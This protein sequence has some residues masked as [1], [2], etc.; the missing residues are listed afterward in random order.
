M[1]DQCIVEIR[2]SADR[3]QTANLLKKVFKNRWQE[4]KAE[5][6]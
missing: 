2:K 5:V 1:S 4:T 6:S 3:G